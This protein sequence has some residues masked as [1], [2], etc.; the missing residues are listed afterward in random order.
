MN[1][2]QQDKPE[3]GQWLGMAKEKHLPKPD[4][5]MSLPK[6]LNTN[7]ARQFFT[8]AAN[9]V[10]F[11]VSSSS[12]YKLFRKRKD[13]KLNIEI[14][15]LHQKRN[16]FIADKLALFLSGKISEFEI[17]EMITYAPLTV[18]EV[19]Q[20]LKEAT[21][22]E[23]AKLEAQKKQIEEDSKKLQIAAQ[24][25]RDRAANAIKETA[26]VKARSQIEIATQRAITADLNV[27]T[28]ALATQTR[29][30]VAQHQSSLF[31]KKPQHTCAECHLRNEHGFEPNYAHN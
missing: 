7:G 17:A 6:Q 11:R 30:T 20:M 18:V 5:K 15:T 26:E 4:E 3:L 21:K 23:I 1:S 27:Q 13:E 16:S 14:N 25:E 31:N 19:E 10:K 2:F 9:K 8:P 28:Q 22:N 24:N 12:D 29:S